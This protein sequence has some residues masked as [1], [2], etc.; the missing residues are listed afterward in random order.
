[1]TANHFSG[2]TQAERRRYPRVPLKLRLEYQCLEKGNVAPSEK[3]L[4]KDLAAGG[5]AMSSERPLPPN[6]LL[7]L[8]LYLPLPEKRDDLEQGESVGEEESVPVNILSR[9]AWCAR[10]EGDFEVGVQFLDMDR[11]DRKTMKSFLIEYRLYPGDP[12]PFL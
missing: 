7:M 10:R 11:D 4:A 9:V 8:T 3:K 2:E 12:T 5:L 6:Q 1:M